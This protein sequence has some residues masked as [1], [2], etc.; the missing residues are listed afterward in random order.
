MHS[1]RLRQ[2]EGSMGSGELSRV[3]GKL[4][5]PKL[6][7]LDI[8]LGCFGPLWKKKWSLSSC[9][10]P[11]WLRWTMLCWS[12]IFVLGLR[13]SEIRL[14]LRHF[15]LDLDHHRLRLFHYC[16]VQALC[17]FKACI[18]HCIRHCI[19]HAS[20]MHPSNCNC[21]VFGCFWCNECDASCRYCVVSRN[22]IGTFHWSLHS[23]IQSRLSMLVLPCRHCAEDAISCM[24]Q[25]E[26]AWFDTSDSRSPGKSSSSSCLGIPGNF[27]TSWHVSTTTITCLKCLKASDLASTTTT[28]TARAPRTRAARSP[29][30]VDQTVHTQ[31]C[32]SSWICVCIWSTSW[33]ICLGCEVATAGRIWRADTALETRGLYM[34][35]LCI[36]ILTYFDT[37]RNLCCKYFKPK[38][39][40]REHCTETFWI[41][42]DA[43][44][45][46]LMDILVASRRQPPA[47][48]R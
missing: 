30:T 47:P 27:T 33:R 24:V 8:V 42:T 9:L 23:K 43:L 20:S 15:R 48:R 7:G 28:S 22:V 32:E 40:Q 44:H 10:P 14:S 46:L 19:R 39:S 37:L 16:D 26:L 4:E 41:F 34:A 25:I 1:L 3:E 36:V 35:L 12:L 29:R 2:R 5:A 17:W 13:E 38:G 31:E 45:A 11:A 6:Q 18:L 21:R